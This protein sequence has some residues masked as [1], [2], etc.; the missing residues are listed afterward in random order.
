[1]TGTQTV[2]GKDGDFCDVPSFVFD[3]ENAAKINNYNNVPP[4]QFETVT[5]HVAWSSAGFS[6]FFDVQDASVQTVNQADPTQ[7]VGKVYLGDSVEVMIS[8]SDAVTG[9]TGTD[10]NT[11][12]VIVPA[13][14]P[15]VSVKT[16]NS[17]GTS[18]GAHTNLPATE[19]AQVKTSTGYAVEVRLPW[20]GGSPV[21]GTQIRFDLALNSADTVFGSLDE[22]RDGQLLY[23][24]GS[25]G[26]TTTCQNSSDGTVPFCDDRLWCSPSL[27]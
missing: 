15:A 1:M 9:L 20:P 8:S 11:L 23:Y 14:G 4:T 7:A 27:Q 13:D 26:G 17:G 2:D 6:G 21:A 12:H 3:V 10:N 24:V 5:A 19:Y 18:S 22:M 16:S 25:V